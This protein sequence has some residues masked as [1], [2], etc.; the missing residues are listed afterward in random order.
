[1]TRLDGQLLDAIPTQRWTFEAR[2]GQVLTFTMQAAD[3]T[4]LDTVLRLYVPDGQKLTEDDDADDPAL[5]K[6]SQLVQVQLPASGTYTLEAS[7]FEGEGHY[8]LVIVE[9]S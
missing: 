3:G 7:R 4:P 9:T 6:N 2:A 1:V 5:G 8:S